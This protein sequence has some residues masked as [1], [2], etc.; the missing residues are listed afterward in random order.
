MKYG[1]S[2]TE[3]VSELILQ[4]VSLI[5][6]SEVKDPGVGFVTLTAV[7]VSDDLRYAKIYIS[8]MGDE[9]EKKRSLRALNR[10]KGFIRSSFG[11]KVRL[12]YLPEMSFYLDRS[13]DRVK[14]IE[15]ILREISGNGNPEV[16]G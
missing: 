3:R 4:E 16:N 2:R 11:T 9:K 13:L 1:Y 7:E 14:R 8:V 6:R 10:A 5:I 12:K 15:D